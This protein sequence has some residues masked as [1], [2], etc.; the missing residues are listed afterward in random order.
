M[1]ESKLFEI[2]KLGDE[3]LDIFLKGLDEQEKE[4]LIKFLIMFAKKMNQLYISYI[5]AQDNVVRTQDL[6]IK[7]SDIVI[8]NLLN[9]LEKSKIE[10]YKKNDIMELMG[11]ES[12]KALRILKVATQAGFGMKMGKDYQIT[13]QNLK[14]FLK[15]YEG[16][17]LNI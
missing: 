10:I 9:R 5:K 16:K 6:S 11:C 14:K 12:D 2:F 8:E 4:E 7:Q 17:P 3:E 13:S 1:E 15:Q